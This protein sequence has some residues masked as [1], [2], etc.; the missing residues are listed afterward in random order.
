M[1]IEEM[2]AQL[3]P[4]EQLE[5]AEKKMQKI[6]RRTKHLQTFDKKYYMKLNQHDLVVLS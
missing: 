1:E 4:I 2:V 5:D 6:K 3:T